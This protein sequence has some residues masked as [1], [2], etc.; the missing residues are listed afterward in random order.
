VRF[1]TFEFDLHS[2]E[3]RNAGARLPVQ[4]QPLLVLITLLE[5]PGDLVTRDELRRRLWP[6]DTFVDFEHGLNAAIQRLR[7]ALGDSAESPQFV[8]TLPRR[9][10]R[11][12]API[13]RVTPAA[14]EVGPALTRLIALPFRVLRS[15]PDTDFLA[16]SLPDGITESLAGLHSLVVR[17]TLAGSKYADSAPDLK[18]LAA[19]TGVDLVLTG[20]LMRAADRL[21]VMAQLVEVPHGTVVWSHT[22]EVV[23]GDLFQLQDDLSQR[24]LASLS[25]SLSARDR[26]VFR[27]DV[28]ANATAYEYYLRGNALLHSSPQPDATLWT[29]ACE[30]YRRA[31]ELDSEYAPAWAQLGR[32]LKLIG[33]YLEPDPHVF[34]SAEAAFRR[35]IAL[36]PELPLAHNL[37]AQLEVDVGRAE[38]AMQRLHQRAQRHGADPELFKGLVH[39]CRYC[40]LLD[41]SVAAHCE[42]VR[43]EPNAE[44]SVV[45]T[46]WMLGDYTRVLTF[47]HVI[48]VIV[49]MSLIML[50]REGDALT[51]ART[52]EGGSDK[53][54]LL[55]TAVRAF[56]EGRPEESLCAL[57]EAANGYRDAE[58]FYYIARL[59]AFFGARDRAV[60]SFRQAVDRGFF[61]APAMARDPWMDGLRADPGFGEAYE[62]A[63]ARH[64]AALATFLEI[65]G[66]STARGLTRPPV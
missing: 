59:Y 49:P 32:V 52:L 6:T 61:C 65:G 33:K 12:V 40:G 16:F 35:A 26:R 54:R 43:L 19:D 56:L 46:Y 13:E 38:D 55:V 9:G 63:E 24:I 34:T 41:A 7:T 14:E 48:H 21:R 36:N 22:T 66:G 20:T 37:Y 8:E 1:G 28:P 47:P 23:M 4:D 29:S 39:A 2:R 62:R 17:S 53:R 45:H 27:R 15:D 44:T 30:F 10:Y 60:A 25:V 3:L 64:R 31:L 58:G 5:Q 57:D 42:A 18:A 11:F 50:G 51:V